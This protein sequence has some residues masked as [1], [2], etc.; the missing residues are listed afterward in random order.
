MGAGKSMGECKSRD[1]LYVM[2]RKWLFSF[3]MNIIETSIII[4][5]PTWLSLF[6]AIKISQI[7]Y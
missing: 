6:I 5:L 1:L 7:V 2:N 4:T 3:R